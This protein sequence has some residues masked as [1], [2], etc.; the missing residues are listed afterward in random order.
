MKGRAAGANQLNVSVPRNNRLVGELLSGD[1]VWV[2]HRED[3]FILIGDLTVFGFDVLLYEFVQVRVGVF[4]AQPKTP[5]VN[6]S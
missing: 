4:E 5:L 3:F 6:R 2:F 1:G